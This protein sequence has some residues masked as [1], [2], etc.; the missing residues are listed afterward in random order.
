MVAATTPT[1]SSL[2]AGSA[3]CWAI[4][5][6]SVASTDWAEERKNWK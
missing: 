5:G 3:P 4:C 6:S 2:D 1:A